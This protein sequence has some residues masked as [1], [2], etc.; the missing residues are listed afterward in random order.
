MEL[1][2][3]QWK[4]I[5]P[6]LIE[7][8]PRE[9]RKGRPRTHPLPILNGILWILRTGAQWSDLPDRFPPYQ[10]CHRR[11]Q[12]WSNNGTMQNILAKLAKDL[13]ERGDIDLTESFIDGMFVPAKKG[14]QK[15]AKPSV[16][17]VQRSWQSETAMVFL[18]P[19]AQKVL[20]H[21]K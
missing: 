4:I 11:F 6:L 2:D 18:S 10:T 12:E 3:Q 13:Q 15:S 7:P 8:K 5:E 21:M 14:A 17:R 19:F 20:L 1:S 9:D 16:G